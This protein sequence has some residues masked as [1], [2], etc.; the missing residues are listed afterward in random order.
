VTVRLDDRLAR[1]SDCDAP[2]ADELS[3]D[4]SPEPALTAGAEFEPG[5]RPEPWPEPEEAAEGVVEEAREELEGEVEAVVEEEMAAEEVVAEEEAVVGEAQQPQNQR[6]ASEPTVRC[7]HCQ[8]E[9]AAGHHV[10][11]ACDRMLVPRSSFG[12]PTAAARAPLTPAPRG[13]VK[14]KAEQLQTSGR[15]NAGKMPRLGPHPKPKPAG[16]KAKGKLPAGTG[17]RP[18][19]GFFAR[20]AAHG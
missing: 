2:A 16:V 19:T 15:A 18:I 13:N 12:T 1:S 8:F 14:R 10:C 7:A 9:N 5:P 20:T 3:M 4:A 17:G 11:V 6:R